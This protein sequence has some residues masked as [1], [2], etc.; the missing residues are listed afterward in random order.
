MW[1]TCLLVFVGRH[2][3]G[4][5]SPLEQEQ[6]SWWCWVW[7]WWK[8]AWL[9]WAWRWGRTLFR[10]SWPPLLK[11]HLTPKSSGLWLKSW[12]NGLKIIPPWQPIR[13][14]AVLWPDDLTLYVKGNSGGITFSAL[15]SESSQS[16]KTSVRP[17]F[18]FT[19]SL[20]KLGFSHCI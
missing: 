16:S 17:I 6:V 7:S 8:H 15:P 12:K 4:V 18:T 11:N 1:S 19:V 9:W 10:P 20:F 14:G 3:W 13:W 2:C 5:L